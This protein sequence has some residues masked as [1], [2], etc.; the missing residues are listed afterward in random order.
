M[1]YQ[2]TFKRYEL[3]YLLNRQ[4]KEQILLAMQPY[5]KL[6]DYGRTVIRNIYFD[7]DTF[8]VSYTHLLVASISP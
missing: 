1:A 4:E 7:T 5:M 8:P 2:T 3:K 6:D